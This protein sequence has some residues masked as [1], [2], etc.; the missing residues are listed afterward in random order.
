MESGA[1]NLLATSPETPPA[2]FECARSLADLTISKTLP[3]TSTRAKV[4][5]VLQNDLNIQRSPKIGREAAAPLLEG[6]HLRQDRSSHNT[7]SDP[8]LRREGAHANT[9]KTRRVLEWMQSRMFSSL[10]V[11][12]SNELFA[13]CK[14][15]KKMCWMT[16]TSF[17]RHHCEPPG[18]S[19][20]SLMAVSYFARPIW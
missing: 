18:T 4:S 2:S 10:C 11:R 12:S 3:S 20:P 7:Q 6:R 16:R 1:T 13:R 9:T 19:T 8:N 15:V 14:Y 17:Q 5:A